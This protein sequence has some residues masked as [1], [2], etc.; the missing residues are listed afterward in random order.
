[1]YPFT[2][3]KLSESF[4]SIFNV[5]TKY[6]DIPASAVLCI[7][8]SLSQNNSMI[9]LFDL[10]DVIRCSLN[11]LPNK[12]LSCCWSKYASSLSIFL[13]AVEH[14][15][16]RKVPYIFYGKSLYFL[17]ALAGEWIARYSPLLCLIL[18]TLPPPATKW[19]FVC[20]I[21]V[22]TMSPLH[23]CFCFGFFRMLPPNLHLFVYGFLLECPSRIRQVSWLCLGSQ[24]RSLWV[25]FVTWCRHPSQ[26][27]NYSLAWFAIFVDK[28][29]LYLPAFEITSKVSV[30]K[31]V[32]VSD[33]FE[34]EDEHFLRW[35]SF[36]FLQTFFLLFF[37]FFFFFRWTKKMKLINNDGVTLNA[38]FSAFYLF[39][40]F[41]CQRLFVE[42]PEPL[43]RWSLID[44]I[45]QGFGQLKFHPGHY[46]LHHQFLICLW[47]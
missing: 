8:L 4:V 42:L 32:S 28:L 19:N 12:F 6:F 33:Q 14:N 29:Y 10:A 39:P 15:L 44:L 16:I 9:C 7:F 21:R 31:S 2:Y 22:W 46:Y 23:R 1:M 40:V 5:S 13:I 3:S 26:L 25:I 45:K 30:S 34:E 41:D 27:S 20:V 35:S 18:L 24:V 47:N 11:F 36:L 43:S 38:F 37:F 17:F